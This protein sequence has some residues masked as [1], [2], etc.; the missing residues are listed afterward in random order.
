MSSLNSQIDNIYD[1]CTSE[2]KTLERLFEE[3]CANSANDQIVVVHINIVSLNKNFDAFTHFLH[4]FPK[5]IDVICLSET[6]LNDR[7]LKYSY[8][9]GYKL[10]C[11]NSSTKAGGSA[12]YAS[13][14]LNCIEL[15]QTKLKCDGCENVWVELK[16]YNNEALIVGSVYRHPNNVIRKFE[17]AFTGIIKSFKIN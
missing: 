17:E 7:N 15:A 3:M 13:D 12:I 8:L 4:R 14:S 11:N 9:P 1:N 2:Y 5:R 16:L 6:R 10:F